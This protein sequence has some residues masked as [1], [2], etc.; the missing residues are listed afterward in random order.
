LI[1]MLGG[2]LLRQEKA[3]AACKPVTNSSEILAAN[4]PQY[5]Q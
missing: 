4:L 3:Y 5:D 2:H 1:L